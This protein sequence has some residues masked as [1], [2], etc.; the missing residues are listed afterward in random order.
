MA[1]AYTVG[2]IGWFGDA[3]DRAVSVGTF[4]WF[5]GITIGV[6]APFV[7]NVSVK[8]PEVNVSFKRPEVRFA[9]K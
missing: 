8:R 1:D 7:V 5:I 3:D 4:G 9:I 6:V 2:T